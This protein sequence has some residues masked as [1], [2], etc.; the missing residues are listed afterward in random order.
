MTVYSRPN[1]VGVVSFAAK[2]VASARI[3]DALNERGICVRAGHHCAPLMHDA[4]GTL[5]SGTVRASVSVDNTADEVDALID[6]LRD[7]LRQTTD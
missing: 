3:A 7:V 1:P 2:Q 4:L 6:A 5:A